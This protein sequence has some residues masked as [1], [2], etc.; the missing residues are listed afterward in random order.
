ARGFAFSDPLGEDASGPAMVLLGEEIAIA[1]HELTVADFTRFWAAAGEA[2]FGA[3][4]PL[5]RD[6]EK[7]FLSGALGKRNWRSPDLPTGAR[8]P[9]VCI[10]HPMAVA[11]ARWLTRQTGAT[12]RLPTAA[13]WRQAH[14]GGGGGAA[15]AE[16]NR[17]DA[18]YRAE[19]GGRDGGTCNDGFAGTAPVASFAARGVGLYD[20]DG[21]VREWVSDCGASCSERRALGG[22]W[23]IDG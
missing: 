20:L 14:G 2:A 13:E 8:H 6:R 23:L 9:V 17:R 3:D 10:S 1:A 4:L 22:A 15:C 18:A 12:Y 19:N 21:N 11:Y 7:G 16:A 5:C